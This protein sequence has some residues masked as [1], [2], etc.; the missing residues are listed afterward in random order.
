MFL[1]EQQI[2]AVATDA[3]ES[4]TPRWGTLDLRFG[5]LFFGRHIFVISEGG[6]ET[7]Y[8]RIES[9]P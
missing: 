7:R 1:Y 2:G 3:N 9:G 6:D 8:S 5:R 4:T